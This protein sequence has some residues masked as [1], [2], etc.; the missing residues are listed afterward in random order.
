MEMYS[1]KD[2]D[3]G[4]FNH[5][6]H[7]QNEIQAIRNV[8]VGLDKTMLEKFPASFALYHMGSFDETKGTFRQNDDQ[9]KLI[10]PVTQII[11]QRTTAEDITNAGKTQSPKKV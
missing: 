7:A 1:I 11:S 6:F 5:P 8:T 10:I 4:T 9:P 3:M 2:N